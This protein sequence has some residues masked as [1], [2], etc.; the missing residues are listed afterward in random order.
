MATVLWKPIRFR[1]AWCS[2]HFK[3]K[4]KSKLMSNFKEEADG[5]L[6]LGWNIEIGM[7]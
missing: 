7:E 1:T 5:I 3:S 2:M 6:K 4:L